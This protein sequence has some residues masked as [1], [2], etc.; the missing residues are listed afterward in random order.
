MKKFADSQNELQESK[1]TTR[2]PEG[3]PRLIPC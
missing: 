1:N 3:Y 2:K